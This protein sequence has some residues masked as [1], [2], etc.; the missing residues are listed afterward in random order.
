M[1]EEFLHAVQRAISRHGMLRPGD[2]VVVGV[3]GGADSVAL[4]HALWSLREELNI[5]LIAAHL[6][7]CIRGKDADRD[8]EFVRGLAAKLDIPSV[9]EKVDVPSLK[10][11][12]RVGMEEAARH[13]RY[14]FFET[15]A[16]S[17]SS[18][19]AVA[20][21]SD[22]QVETVLLNIIRGTGPDGLAGMPAVRGKIIRPLIDI[23]RV[24]VEEY[25]RKRDLTWRIDITNLEPD[26]TRNR[27]RLQLIPF[28]EG[29]FNPRIKD[30][31]LSLQRIMS[32]ETD[33]MSA[34]ARQA[35]DAAAAMA[36]E[37]SVTFDAEQLR[38][39][40][41]AILRRCLRMGIECVRGDL[42]DVEFGQVERVIEYLSAGEDFVLT[43]PS[44]KVYAGLSGSQFRI[45]RRTEPPKP[46][47]LREIAVP[48]V[49]EIPEMGVGI[50]TR[51]VSPET[52]PES[53]RQ[54]VI[55]L[56]SIRGR[57]MVRGWQP[58]DRMTPL[59]M[60]GQKKLQ[61]I[62]IDRK[63]PRAERGMTPIIVDEAKIVWVAGTALS[64]LAK[65]TNETRRA[66]LME[67]VEP[68]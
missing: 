11:E 33:V 49:T 57:L 58:G 32:D 25:L 43:L 50:E 34:S 31:I 3:S 13:A 64:D 2:T 41:R 36:D 5:D 14:R 62:F 7:H 47:I 67:I 24:E 12:K 26:Y 56:D 45:F 17:A 46:E 55:D 8:A 53:P 18:K 6:N 22:D 44:G 27:V 63:V 35:Y 39:Y 21:T 54:A 15:V 4:L 51:I 66:L 68:V 61:D 19:I 59:G 1:T 40:S 28:L 60:T 10:R 65:I 29:Q 23:S 52:R 9:I 20:H 42:R 16:A 38:S 37:D 30:A 48:G